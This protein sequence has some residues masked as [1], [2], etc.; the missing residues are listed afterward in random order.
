MR[1]PDGTWI[2]TSWSLRLNSRASK[3]GSAKRRATRICRQSNVDEDQSSEQGELR[4]RARSSGM[5]G[6]CPPGTQPPDARA[7]PRARFSTGL[8]ESWAAC[9]HAYSFQDPE[10]T[11]V[12]TELPHVSLRDSY[13]PRQWHLHE[14]NGSTPRTCT[15]AGLSTR[16]GGSQDGGRH[17][18][19]GA[20][21]AAPRHLSLEECHR[22]TFATVLRSPNPDP[23]VVLGTDCRGAK[24]DRDRK[25]D[26]PDAEAAR[27]E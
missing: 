16:A 21:L 11:E 23:H 24:R 8:P 15:L 1:C 2:V 22:T 20:Q 5:K 19:I 9:A 12:L 18:R 10:G 25:A 26:R 6:R 14:S 7:A 17:G 13:A 4:R 27:E 3:S